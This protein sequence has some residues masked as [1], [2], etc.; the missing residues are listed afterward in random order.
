MPNPMPSPEIDFHISDFD[1]YATFLSYP[2]A[3]IVTQRL[4][5]QDGLKHGI[6]KRKYM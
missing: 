5:L 6:L 1:I 2:Y 4:P 3:S